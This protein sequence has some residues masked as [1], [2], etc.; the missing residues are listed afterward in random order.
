MMVNV[1]VDLAYANL[2][3]PY[4]DWVAEAKEFKNGLLAARTLLSPVDECHCINLIN[5]LNEDRILKRG[6][7]L[8]VASPAA[9]VS[10]FCRD[11]MSVGRNVDTCNG[12][13]FADADVS[14]CGK[15]GAQGEV[16][17]ADCPP[18]PATDQLPRTDVLRSD[19][20]IAR[21]L[22][23]LTPST[24]TPRDELDGEPDRRLSS[25]YPIYDR[26]E[27]T[28]ATMRRGVE[29][30]FDALNAGE[31]KDCESNATDVSGPIA[32]FISDSPRICDPRLRAQARPFVPRATK[33]AAYLC[34]GIA[35]PDNSVEF[36]GH[37]L[38]QIT[39]ESTLDLAYLLPVINSLP[40]DLTD[41]QR[42]IAI[43]LI[44]NNK[45]VFS[46]DEFDLGL[47]N[48]LTMR[49]ETYPDAKPVCQSLRSHAKV[50]L[51]LIDETVGKMEKAGIVE[52]AICSPWAS[53]LV[54]VSK[55]SG[56]PRVTV[57]HRGLNACCIKDKFP[58]PRI[59]DCFDALS[60]STFFSI[61]DL[62]SSYHQLLLDPRD[63]YKTAFITRLGSWQY[64]R[65][66]MGH[67][68]SALIFLG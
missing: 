23:P 11:Y 44:R 29:F 65:A 40:K 61:L 27:R 50:H 19:L 53:N 24:G 55:A 48:M 10:R 14:G 8:G 67:V 37:R 9:T 51:D 4:T 41:E 13:Q 15:E 26:H 20:L 12:L 49:I 7:Y 1:P 22:T 33:A 36:N 3:S 42:S 35:L 38:L 18:C 28:D 16:N 68:N 5:V 60:G 43:E 39:E 62:S 59:S 2:H 17:D 63:R 54:I 58:L 56:E 34:N 66:P 46:R 57:D 45:D 32:D 30:H 25:E 52:K 47:S 64:C 6:S 21:E 31:L